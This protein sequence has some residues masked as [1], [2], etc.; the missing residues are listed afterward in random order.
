MSDEDFNED[1]LRAAYR[2]WQASRAA[3]D[4][5]NVG[6][7]ALSPDALAALVEDTGDDET[8]LAA[9]DAALSSPSSAAELSLLLAARTAAEAAMRGD[10]PV[11]Q[12]PDSEARVRPMANDRSTP[13]R[14]PMWR[15]VLPLAAATTLVVS[16]G[17][18][19]WQ[20][21]DGGTTRSGET[22]PPVPLIGERVG[23][24]LWHSVAEATSYRVEVLD[25]KGAPIL[26]V[27]EPDTVAVL[28]PGF[29]A[30]RWS[31]WW[32]R[33]YSG[34]REIAASPMTAYYR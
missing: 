25:E 7:A 17:A 24:L 27:T 33:A 26:T 6:D 31:S 12:N 28:P 4:A 16:G 20:G 8:R 30:P 23:V 2:A 21:R 13:R 5:P 34:R 32:V 14:A 15:R 3:P 18:L 1:R 11:S 29:D 9:L 22:L 19:W 10:S